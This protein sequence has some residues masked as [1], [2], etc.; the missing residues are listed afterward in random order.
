MV[1]SH[2]QQVEGCRMVIVLTWL[3][4]ATVSAP[5]HG[6]ERPAPAVGKG[7]SGG[8]ATRLHLTVQQERLSVDLWEAEIG[9]VLARLGQD[10]GVLI[11][12]SPTSGERISAQ[13]TNVELE[14]GLRRLLRLAALSYAIRYAEGPTGAV[15]V[16]EV[17][18]FQAAPE[19][20]LP[21]P[22][23]TTRDAEARA[24]SSAD[25]RG[26]AGSRWPTPSSE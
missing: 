25:S 16:N 8:R 4:V 12:G 10:A 6:L 24:A 7:H 9:E 13:F 19:G 23:D 21:L 5:G 2:R 15:T 11:T 14:V 18:V 1:T 3:I 22:H 20:S 17:R 26:R